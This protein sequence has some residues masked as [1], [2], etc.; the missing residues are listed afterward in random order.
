[1]QKLTE[2]V[3]LTDPTT[4]LPPKT[5]PGCDICAALSQQWRQA[6]TVG[7]PAFDRSHAADL[8]AEIRRH[9]HAKRRT[10]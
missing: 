6:S 2:A 8:A 3:H 4:A 5:P 10:A 7:S 1:M 9:P